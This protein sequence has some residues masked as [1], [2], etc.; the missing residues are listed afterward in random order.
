MKSWFSK[1]K[2]SSALD[3]RQP[4]PESLRRKIDADP[5][6]QR[7]TQRAHAL[8]E[9]LR[10]LPPSG[11]PLHDSIMRAVRSTARRDEARRTPVLWW[12]TASGAVAAVAVFCLL[13][14]T[15]LRPKTLARQSLDGPATVLEMIEKMPATVPSLAMSP[16]SDE[17]AR[18]DHDLQD[19][20]Q[21]LL[22]SFP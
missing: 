22:A 18:V 4:L 7:F 13:H 16:L 8:G 14:F 15:V 2:I 20:A 1:W 19:T 5:E 9:T 11:P 21:V 6:L 12:A 3:S 17:S 10:S